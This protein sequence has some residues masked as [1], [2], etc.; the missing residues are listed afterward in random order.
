MGQAFPVELSRPVETL[1]SYANFTQII[2]RNARTSWTAVTRV[3]L[4]IT[5]CMH[6][7]SY[8]SGAGLTGINLGQEISMEGEIDVPWKMSMVGC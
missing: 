7:C 2:S 8:F 3:I 1:S 5:F 4:M 6:S